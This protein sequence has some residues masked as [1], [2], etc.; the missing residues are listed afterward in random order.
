MVTLEP[1]PASSDQNASFVPS[2]REGRVDVEAGAR[3]EEAWVA[4]VGIGD[5]DVATGVEGDEPV[6]GE[7]ERRGGSESGFGEGCAPTP[8]AA[9]EAMRRL[10]RARMMTAREPGP[11]R[12]VVCMGSHLSRTAQPGSRR[13]VATSV[14][15]RSRS[16]A[17]S[18]IGACS[19]SQAVRMRS[20]VGRSFMSSVRRGVAVRASASSAARSCWVVRE[21]LDFTVPTGMPSDL[22]R[23]LY[24]Q[25][26]VVVQ[27]EQGALLGAQGREAALQLV[28][29]G[30]RACRG[31][32]R[33]M[34]MSGSGP[35]SSADAGSGRPRDSRP[36]RAGGGARPRSGPGHAAR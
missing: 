31:P 28:L 9:S 20:D 14:V 34:G 4:A 15:T 30:D 32:A 10:R 16:P 25:A 36:G 35:R 29:V 3:D 21:S 33:P 11:R 18:L 12:A 24:R 26:Q 17:G 22:G 7:P 8:M 2:G 1:S 19:S 27:D 13:V 23:L 5:P 6:P